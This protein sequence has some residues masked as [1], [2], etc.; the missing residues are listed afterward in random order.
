MGA[1]DGGVIIAA[2]FDIM[3]ISL[4]ADFFQSP[5]LLRG[6]RSQGSAKF[7]ACLL[8]DSTVGI[9]DPVEVLRFL[10]SIHAPAAENEGEMTDTGGFGRFRMPK[11]FIGV[12][13]RIDG[14][15]GLV[16]DRLGAIRAVFAAM[17]GTTVEDRT[18]MDFL[19]LI[20]LT[21]RI[22]GREQIGQFGIG[23]PGKF[24]SFRQLYL[25]TVQ[26]FL[27]KFIDPFTHVPAVPPVIRR[28]RS[29]SAG[30]AS[31]RRPV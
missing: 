27:H 3:V 28:G 21:N 5:G 12:Q 25:A 14:H 16:V 13:Q 29:P 6:Q 18:E 11:D 15:S 26:Y 22:G 31:T 23:D 19:S 8:Q 30:R 10:G 4:H 9:D 20:L 1:A 24:T 7:Q 17:A 2:G